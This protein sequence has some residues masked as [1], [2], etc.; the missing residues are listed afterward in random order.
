[1]IRLARAAMLLALL[2]CE[3]AAVDRALQRMSDQP[4]YQGYRLPPAGT[5]AR[6]AELD[7][8]APPITSELLAVGQSRFRIFCSPC[9][10]EAGFGGSVVAANMTGHRPPSLRRPELARLP[11][12]FYY[13]VIT[14][15]VGRMPSYAAE[16]SR[17]ERWAVI[18]YL[19]QLQRSPVRTAEEQADSA[20]GARLRE[21]DSLAGRHAPP[22]GPR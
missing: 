4:R 3:R 2:G 8:T 15:G 7:S 17:R 18:A 19:Q 10:G 14:R 16:L 21:L 1:M 6:E 20:A 9:H 11:P 12:E 22:T 5:V 13:G